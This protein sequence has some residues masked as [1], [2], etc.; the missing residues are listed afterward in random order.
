MNFDSLKNALSNIYI[1]KGLNFLFNALIKSKFYEDNSINT[2]ACMTI[3]DQKIH[4]YINTNKMEELTKQDQLFVLTHELLHSYQMLRIM[5]VLEIEKLKK[6]NEQTCLFYINIA[7]DM[8]VNES[9]LRMN[10]FDVSDTLLSKIIRLKNEALDFDFSFD[11]GWESIY[12]KLMSTLPH[13]EPIPFNQDISCSEDS[14]EEIKDLLD[15]I[16]YSDYLSSNFTASSKA[17][18]KLSFYT[19]K[20]KTEPFI[21]S[22]VRKIKAIGKTSL[23][24]SEETFTNP[25][26]LFPE[27]EEIAGF[28]RTEGKGSC[29]IIIDTS[30]SMNEAF[31]KTALSVFDELDKHTIVE[32]VYSLDTTLTNIPIKDLRNHKVCLVGNGGTSFRPFHIQEIELQRRNN[33]PTSYIYVT[34]GELDLKEILNF[35]RIKLKKHRLYIVN[36]KEKYF[37]R[38]TP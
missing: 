35:F 3:K 13:K 28:E 12:K 16:K 34:D 22:L 14:I 15:E 36:V 21:K 38:R 37:D 26:P 7:T 23:S 4:V 29:I 6:N 18:S 33:S 20:N 24:S 31:L 11:E 30:A 32:K 9:I 19:T 17:E 10:L 25:H 5:E 27:Q 2:Y 8:M 1:N